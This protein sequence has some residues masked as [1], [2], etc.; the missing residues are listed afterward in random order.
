MGDNRQHFCGLFIPFRN[1]TYHY[2]IPWLQTLL[3]SSFIGL[4]LIPVVLGI[5]KA[6]AQLH[7]ELLAKG[8][9]HVMYHIFLPHSPAIKGLCCGVTEAQALKC[10]CKNAIPP[11]LPVWLQLIM[12]LVINACISRVAYL[13]ICKYGYSQGIFKVFSSSHSEDFHWFSHCGLLYRFWVLCNP[14]PLMELVNK[15]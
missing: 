11:G 8:R 12:S 1:P 14:L 4:K 15:Q 2:M 7:T 3:I 10:S 6:Q 9:T 13:L 5:F